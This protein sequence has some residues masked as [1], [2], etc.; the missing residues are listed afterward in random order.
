MQIITVGA[1]TDAE[2]VR[3]ASRA[4]WGPLLEA[5]IQIYEYQPTLYHCK[6]MIVDGL[7]VTVG[8]TNFD[9]RSFNLNDEANLSY[10][11]ADFSR[12]QI[13]IFQQDLLHS[14]QMTLEQWKH[15]P[16]S[17]RFWDR[18]ASLLGSQL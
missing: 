13:E 9:P 2:L 10:F 5:G 17:E 8:S 12:R 16:L 18:A 11:D 15:R 3:H 1:Q 6:V 4:R 14:R 7:W